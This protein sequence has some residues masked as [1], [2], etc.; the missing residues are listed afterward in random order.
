MIDKIYNEDCLEG[1]KK[2]P[3]GSIDMI[4]TD[5]PYGTTACAWDE[6]IPFEPMWEQYLRV[7]KENG[8]I[9]LFGSEPFSTKLRSSRL[10]LYRYDWVWK[11][12]RF[13]NQMLA[14]K[15]PLKITE[16]IMVFYRKQPTY[17]P[18]G[19]KRVNKV[20][21]QGIT[22][23][24]NNGGG[25]RADSYVQEYTGYPRNVLEFASASNTV[26]STQKPTALLSYLIKTYTNPGETILD[27]CTGGG[28]SSIIAA[29]H[30]KR[31]FIGF[32]LDEYYYQVSQ[33]RI[34]RYLESNGK[35][36]VE[37]CYEKDITGD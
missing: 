23:S 8:A 30:T 5:L 1:M 31:H 24:D 19:L 18:Q 14:H 3:S 33:D 25:L 7:I 4:L 34:R 6:V 32:E 17:N 37:E 36:T 20:T 13:A 27:S 15:Q 11:K 26:H 16:D 9:V 35:K 21:R 2:I 28:G 10:D 29:L 12:S 22:V